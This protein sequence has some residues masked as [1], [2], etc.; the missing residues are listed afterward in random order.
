M[1]IIINKYK[2]LHIFIKTWK[3]NT[4]VRER[5]TSIK[6]KFIMKKII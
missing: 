3:I 2:K 1:K 5:K 6:F 4:V